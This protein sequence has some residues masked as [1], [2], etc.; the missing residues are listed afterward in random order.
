M[1]DLLKAQRAVHQQT[2]ALPRA[3]ARFLPLDP[4]SGLLASGKDILDR[5]LG[6]FSLLPFVG[7][8]GHKAGLAAD[9]GQGLEVARAVKG[10]AAAASSA[11]DLAAAGYVR[12]FA[13]GASKVY[14][15]DIASNGLN[16]AS[17]ITINPWPP[18]RQLPDGTWERVWRITLKEDM[19]PDVQ[20]D[21]LSSSIS[22][23]I[24]A[25]LR[26]VDQRLS[27]IG[28]NDF[29]VCLQQTAPREISVL[30]VTQQDGWSDEYYFAT[31]RLFTYIEERIGTI[32]KI[33]RQPKELWRP[34]RRS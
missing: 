17:T 15:K 21:A 25:D 22:T 1:S 29:A 16:D 2:H 14:A 27:H 18:V 9:A 23:Q 24:V 31:Y 20:L 33:E 7:A 3:L 11:E 8:V 12:A 5:G 13:H 10:V 19:L 6:A 26:V 28:S 4:W 30:V 34:W 32:D